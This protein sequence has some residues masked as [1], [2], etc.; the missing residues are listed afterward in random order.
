[1]TTFSKSEI[2]DNGLTTKISNNSKETDTFHPKY[3]FS[4]IAII[5]VPAVVPFP[6]IT[7]PNAAPPT[8]PPPIA[9][10]NELCGIN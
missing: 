7:K 2:I 10:N 9:A 3:F 8:T 6:N 4:I 5:S 1:M